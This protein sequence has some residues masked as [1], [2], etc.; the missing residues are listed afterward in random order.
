LRKDETIREK[1]TFDPARSSYRALDQYRRRD[2]WLLPDDD[3]AS[4]VIPFRAPLRCK[5]A[6]PHGPRKRWPFGP[7]SVDKKANDPFVSSKQ[8][9][10]A[11]RGGTT[12]LTPQG[13]KERHMIATSRGAGNKHLSFFVRP[14]SRSTHEASARAWRSQRSFSSCLQPHLRR[15]HRS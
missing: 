6:G 9:S 5:S 14:F 1:K 4:G 13:S 2:I 7:V 10:R 12:F 3:D 11:L 15:K 8:Q